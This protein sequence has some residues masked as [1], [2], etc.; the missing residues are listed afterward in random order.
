MPPNVCAALALLQSVPSDSTHPYYHP[1]QWLITLAGTIIAAVIA[2]IFDNIVKR[3]RDHRG[4][5]VAQLLHEMIAEHQ[6]AYLI[7]FVALLTGAEFL[8]I[9]WWAKGVIGVLTFIAF[10][11]YLIAVYLT[12]LHEVQL[13]KDH[14]CQGS[15][16]AEPLSAW[17][18][19]KLCWLTSIFT[20]L[21]LV[22][23][24]VLAFMTT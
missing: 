20:L 22:S 17:A 21:L 9:Y 3:M 7:Y 23:S 2:V 6:I 4:H 24:I 16:C 5:N 12:S 15:G 13:V 19:F 14:Q 10:A 11:F 18:F 1:I 8:P